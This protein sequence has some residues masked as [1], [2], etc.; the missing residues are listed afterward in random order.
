VSN[1]TEHKNADQLEI[2]HVDGWQTCVKKDTFAVNDLVVYIPPDAILPKSLHEF[3]GITKYC[4]HMP[5]GSLEHEQE[6]VRVRATRLRGERSFG[7]V[8]TLDDVHNY[9][10]VVSENASEFLG[11]SEGDDLTEALGITKY[12]PPERVYDGDAEKE[13]S[14]FPKYTD[15]ERYQNYPRMLCEGEPVVMLEKV[16]GSSN[17]IGLIRQDEEF[18]LVAGS[19][20]LQRKRNEESLYWKPLQW[21]PQIDLLLHHIQEQHNANS[22]VLYSEIIGPSI[23]DMVYSGVLTC[24]AFDISVDLKYLDWN[25]TKYYLDMFNVLCVP[26]L[27]EGPFSVDK[28]ME[29]TDGPTMVCENPVGKFK[30]REGCVVKPLHERTDNMGRRVILKSVSVEYLSRKGATDNA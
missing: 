6:K 4:G 15:I 12:T 8:M 22:V 29:Y 11:F 9:L 7:T 20:R 14:L 1:I 5:K 28:L 23:Q 27:Y 25:D 13:N 16:H 2:L 21:F 18:T 19:H 17:R 26:V 10:K 30:G 24:L 3:L